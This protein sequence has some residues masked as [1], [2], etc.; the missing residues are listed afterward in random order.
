MGNNK[1]KW[2]GLTLVCGMSIL[3]WRYFQPVKD[4]IF[5]RLFLQD[6]SASQA[7]IGHKVNRALLATPFASAKPQPLTELLPDAHLLVIYASWCEPCK[8]LLHAYQTQAT[9][10]T[11]PLYVLSFNQAD[12][13]PVGFPI[14]RF[15]LAKTRRADSIFAGSSYPVLWHFAQNG[16]VIDVIVGYDEIIFNEWLVQWQQT[17][18]IDS[19]VSH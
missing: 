3:L 2:L 8:T 17:A 12:I 18:L 10:L 11:P 7:L 5:I 13:P 16:Q 1:L 14:E 15:L 6:A 9:P 19:E 4:M